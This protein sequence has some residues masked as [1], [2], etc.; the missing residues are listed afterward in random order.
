MSIETIPISGT[1]TAAVAD[2]D[3]NSTNGRLSAPRWGLS[4]VTVAVVAVAVTYVNGF[5]ITSLEEAV[6]AIE[7]TQH[8]LSTWMRDSTLMLPLMVLAVFA[9]LRLTRRLVGPSRREI[10]QV[11]TAALLMI[12]FCSVVSIG[13]V[14][15]NAAYNYHVQTGQQLAAVHAV[16]APVAVQG[17]GGGCI[18][19]CAVQRATLMTHI[20]AVGYA[21]VV[22]LITN[23]V[24]VLWS[25]AL[26]GGRLWGRV[27]APSDGVG[28]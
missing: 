25:L 10:A 22:L 13:E 3:A 23:V 24:L 5:W 18:G 16:H 1:L 19:L 12:L 11:A 2:G 28:R 20:R 15:V 8:P 26:R 21:S 17:A 4:W 7:R 14:A 9:A 27:T 6:G